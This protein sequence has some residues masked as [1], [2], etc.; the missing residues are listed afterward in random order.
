M[1]RIL[2]VDDA[3]FMRLVLRNIM[4]AAGH[5]VVGEA[6]N[7]QA[8]VEKYVELKPDLTLMDMVMPELGGVEAVRKIRELDPAA[9]ILMC[10]ATGQE[11]LIQQARE[12][13]VV[14]FVTKPFQEADV[15]Q[16]VS[17]VLAG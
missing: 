11:A 16:A 17:G 6:G 4:Q 15:V 7:G 13:G 8:G 9:R 1:A 3:S 10:S 14:G 12:A 2:I 5:E